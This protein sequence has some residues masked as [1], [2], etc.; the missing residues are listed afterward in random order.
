VE[1]RFHIDPATDEPHIV[2]H[3]VNEEEVEELFDG[4]YEDRDAGHGL[5][6][7]IGQTA[8]GRY[9]RIVYRPMPDHLFVITA[10][11][12]G[13]KSLTAFRRRRRRRRGR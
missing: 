2:R 11:D 10:Y 8:A 3:Q 5:R 6:Y 13:N 1:I 4:Y 12:L 7:A 9:L